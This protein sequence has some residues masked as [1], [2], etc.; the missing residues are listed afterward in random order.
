MKIVGISLIKNEDLY[1]EQVLK[2]T[3]DFCDEII[4]LDNMSEDKTFEIVSKMAKNNSKIKLFRIKKASE[5]HSFIEN[6]ANTNTWIFKIDGDEIYDASGL[7]KLRE[8]LFSGAYQ[9][10]W[11]VE[12][13]SLN[14][15]TLNLSQKIAT[16]YLAPPAKLAP[17]LF[18]FGA[19]KSWSENDNERL[20]G[21][22]V[23]FKDGYDRLSC[24]QL[25][26]ERS[27]D[28]S[29]FRC[30][31]LCFIHRSS[32]EKNDRSYRP[33]PQESMDIY[34]KI[35]NILRNILQGRFSAESNYKINKY[36]KGSRVV[37]DINDFF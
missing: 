32:L 13:P 2:N 10:F 33:N 35:L 17:I 3:L 5:S 24:K 26:K 4:V 23:I 30:L 8:I 25:F 29:I 20:H 1:I 27:W 19:I 9:K 36:K 34:R 31:H 12:G 22:N 18:N 7:R 37:K 14:C 6:Y 28:S 16:G 15:D 11:R 21:N